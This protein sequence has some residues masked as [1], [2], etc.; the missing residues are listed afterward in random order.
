MLILL[1]F[2]RRMINNGVFPLGSSVEHPLAGH[3][4]SGQRKI[5]KH[6]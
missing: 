1:D 4:D 5:E 6:K 2:L 3:V